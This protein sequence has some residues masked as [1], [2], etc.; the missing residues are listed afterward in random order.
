[1]TQ[2]KLS[3]LMKL[4]YKPLIL[5]ILMMVLGGCQPETPNV[6]IP[7]LM[8]LP[9]EAPTD[10]PTETPTETATEIPSNTPTETPTPTHTPTFTETATH[11]H[12][13]TFTASPTVTQTFTHTP[14]PT[15]PPPS[16]T[17]TFTITPTR[18]ATNTRVPTRTATPTPTETPTATIAMPRVINFGVSANNVIAGSTVTFVWNAEGESA[19]LD[20]LN[21]TGAVLASIPVP[22]SGQYSQVITSAERMAIYRLVAIRA[23]QETSSN[24]SVL[25]SCAVPFFFG[26]AIA[27]TNAACPTEGARTGTGAYQVFERGLMLHVAATGINKVYG[28]VGTSSTYSGAG[29]GWD[30]STLRNDPAPSGLVMPQDVF[31]WA[32][33]NTLA[34]IGGW[35][36][37]IGWALAGIDNS[38]RTI[39]YEGAFG[40]GGAFYIDAPGNAIYRFSGGDSGTWT[41][42]R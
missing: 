41:R 3:S 9:T 40:G 15:L 38:Q 29:N 14:I 25:V 26:D 34:P 35:N 11:T 5:V 13:A 23:G 10:I 17:P 31:N 7:T 22:I 16:R 36:S 19:R 24:V 42:L 27:P 30:G 32:Y 4:H 1:M 20:H 39:Q 21:S 18:R 28:L 2:T 8:V 12:T 37:A 33:Y 6:V